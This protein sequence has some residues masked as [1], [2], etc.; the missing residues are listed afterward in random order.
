M[1]DEVV[2]LLIKRMDSNPE[3]FCYGWDPDTD[4]S[5]YS[6]GHRTPKW[7]QV[8]YQLRQRVGELV[9][10][11]NMPKPLPFLSDEQIARLYAKYVEVQGNE[12]EKYVLRTLLHGDDTVRYETSGREALRINASGSIGIGTTTPATVLKATR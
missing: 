12:F 7:R 11:A 3:E 9:Q 5:L 6:D 4:H 1:M 2:D 8:I 10:E